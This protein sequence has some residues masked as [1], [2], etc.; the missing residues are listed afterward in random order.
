[1]E[2]PVEGERNDV[3]GYREGYRSI[4]GNHQ[5]L[6]LSIPGSDARI[7]QTTV[8][9]TARLPSSPV[10]SQPPFPPCQPAI[11]PSVLEPSHHRIK[12]KTLAAS[13]S[14]EAPYSPTESAFALARKGDKQITGL[15]N[16]SPIRRQLL[17]LQRAN[18]LNGC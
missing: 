18:G 9:F 13:S 15:I 4:T 5:Q 14:V 10:A 8:K 16:H 6:V 7:N 17:S 2:T 12:S 3:R 11:E 1:M